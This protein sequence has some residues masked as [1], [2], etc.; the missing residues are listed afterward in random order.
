MAPILSA[1]NG[2]SSAVQIDTDADRDPLRS[3][4]GVPRPEINPRSAHDASNAFGR[5][6]PLPQAC[7]TPSMDLT[8]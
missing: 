1:H 7:Q 4:I 2:T 6:A 8:D 3:R 5:R